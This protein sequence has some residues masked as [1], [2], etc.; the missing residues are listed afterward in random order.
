M[1]GNFQTIA[2]TS[3]ESTAGQ[4]G[5]AIRGNGDGAWRIIDGPS[6][7]R[8]QHMAVPNI[9][10]QQKASGIATRGECPAAKANQPIRL[11]LLRMH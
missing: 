3:T 11:I 6:C 5:A 2:D 9:V 1:L 4:E 7:R 8:V 10:F